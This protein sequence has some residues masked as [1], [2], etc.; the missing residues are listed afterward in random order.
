MIPEEKVKHC[1][2]TVLKPVTCE[3]IVRCCRIEAKKVPF[4][5]ERSVP[6]VV[7][8]QVPVQVY[9][10]KPCQPVCE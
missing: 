5:I 9:K 8:Y 7:S 1:S 10:P 4:T 6:K 3:K 2:Y